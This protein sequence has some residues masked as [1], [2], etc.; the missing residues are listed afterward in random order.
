MRYELFVL[1]I[2]AASFANGYA[3]AP[4]MRRARRSSGATEIAVDG[5][6]AGLGSTRSARQRREHVA[7]NASI[8]S[9]NSKHRKRIPTGDGTAPE[10]KARRRD[11]TVGSRH[12]E[13]TNNNDCRT[14]EMYDYAMAD[15]D[16]TMA[17]DAA[18][19]KNSNKYVRVK[20]ET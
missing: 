8:D 1:F 13:T 18:S 2:V 16:E 11:F 20:F 5:R 10:S 7:S 6:P 17:V 12:S 9:E 3:V 4:A 14:T 19:I 15:D